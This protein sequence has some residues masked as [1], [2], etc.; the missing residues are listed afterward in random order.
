MGTAATGLVALI[1]T[2]AALPALIAR[3]RGGTP[4]GP[5]PK[6]AALAP[7]GAVL[8]IA[9]AAVAAA[10]AWWLLLPLLVPALILASWQRPA[11][12]PR[13]RPRRLVALVFPVL[14]VLPVALVFPVLLA[15]SGC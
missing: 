5:G 15:A 7:V 11:S 2:A 14:L 10:A 9:G 1:L 4:P 12:R 8:A 6:L 3:A 13:P